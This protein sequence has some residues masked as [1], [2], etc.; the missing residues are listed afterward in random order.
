VSGDR[1]G[2][3]REEDKLRNAFR[4]HCK[5]DIACSSPECGYMLSLIEVFWKPCAG[6][7]G[8]SRR[9]ETRVGDEASNDFDV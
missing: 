6:V 2:S 4:S 3:L 8:R 9:Q 7:V 1:R 5:V